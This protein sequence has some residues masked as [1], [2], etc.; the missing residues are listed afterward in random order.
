MSEVQTVEAAKLLLERRQ[1]R[2]SLVSWA[3]VCGFEPAKHHRF[4]IDRLEAVASGDIKRLLITMPPGSAKSTYGSVLFPP[5]YLAQ[6][7]N[8]SILSISHSADFAVSFGRKCRNLVIDH[9]K[10]LGYGLRKDSQAADEWA[11]TNGSVYFCAG[12]GKAIA[13]RRA[14]VGFIDDP[15]GNREDAWSKT[16]RERN[17]NWFKTDFRTRLKPGAAIILIQTRWHEEDLAGCILRDEASDWVVINLPMLAS[18]NDPLDRAPGEML[19]NDYFTP[20]LL[21]DA[22]KDPMVFSAL[23]QGDPTPQDGD[24]FKRDWIEAYAYNYEDLPPM[25]E[26]RVYVASDHAVSEEESADLSAFVPVGVD[27]SGV[28]WILPDVYWN[29]CDALV[30]VQEMITMMKRR[31]PLT[32]WAE[33][34]KITKAMGPFLKRAMREEGVFCYVEEVT[35]SGDKQVRAQSIRGRMAAGMIRFPRFAPW[36]NDALTQFMKFPAGAKDDFVDALAY[37][38]LGLDKMGTG[39]QRAP[40]VDESIYYQSKPITLGWIKKSDER[41]RFNNRLLLVDN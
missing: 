38:G 23:Y 26:L 27:S 35:P 9:E 39:T 2:R 29:R 17:Y 20:A 18:A 6:K 37:I 14:D 16:I 40:V 32:W 7:P 31:K 11:T 13:G 15:V 22:Q 25:D 28:T 8:S 19:W 5:W 36:Y 21:R 30:G 3:R 24:Y 33:K 41:R 1:A 34:E 12:I 10:I 4:L